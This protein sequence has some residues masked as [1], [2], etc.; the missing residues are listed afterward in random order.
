MVSLLCEGSTQ[1]I[2]FYLCHIVV[3]ALLFCC[4]SFIAICDQKNNTIIW[5]SCRAL[6]VASG[7]FILLPTEPAGSGTMFP[8][9]WI[10]CCVSGQSVCWDCVHVRAQLFFAFVR[11]FAFL[12]LSIRS[13]SG[14]Y[15][16]TKKSPL[17]PMCKTS[18]CCAY[19][20]HR[21]VP[22]EA[23]Q[24]LSLCFFECVVHET[25][26][27]LKCCFAF[28]YSRFSI[29]HVHYFFFG[30]VKFCYKTHQQEHTTPRTQHT[31]YPVCSSVLG[32]GCVI[33]LAL[34]LLRL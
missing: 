10:F 22:N 27:S 15:R 17:K 29:P 23:I 6:R 13:S 12:K 3:V 32:L 21:H 18:L 16:W 1:R 14:Y 25:F 5:L 34:L 2:A 26:L 7:L 4:S 24:A 11:Y 28:V 30:P 33:G 19:M 9:A 8:F 20:A 31:N